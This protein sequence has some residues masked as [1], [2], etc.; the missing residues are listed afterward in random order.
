[1]S[2]IKNFNKVLSAITAS[3]L[4]IGGIGFIVWWDVIRVLKLRKNQGKRY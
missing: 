3:A 1:M 2:K 4:V